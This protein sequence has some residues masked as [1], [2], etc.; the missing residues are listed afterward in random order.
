MIIRK[1]NLWIFFIIITACAPNRSDD[2]VP[3]IP[4]VDIVMNLSLPE[5]I[6]LRTDGGYAQLNGGVRGIIVYRVN[7]SSY[8]AYE[9]NC[10][11]HPNDAC[12]TVNVHVSGLFM[13]DPCCGSSF[14][15]SDGNPTGGPA[16]R[17]LVRYRSQLSGSTLTISSDV[18]N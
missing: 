4:F 8:V 14:N 3:F 18:I 1:S 2:P 6:N 11:F 9:R 12:A 13:Q 7:S 5:Y 17:P 10:S 15:F 16:S